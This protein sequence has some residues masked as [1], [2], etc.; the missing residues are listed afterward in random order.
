MQVVWVDIKLNSH[1]GQDLDA[2]AGKVHLPPAMVRADDAVETSF[3]CHDCV[4]GRLYPLWE[5]ACVRAH[6]VVSA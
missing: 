1:F 3:S 5:N 6:G 4:L 2:R